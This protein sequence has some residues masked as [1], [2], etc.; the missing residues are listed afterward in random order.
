MLCFEDYAEAVGEGEKQ[1][2]VD[3]ENQWIVVVV[4]ERQSL[5]LG[6]SWPVEMGTPRKDWRR[7]ESTSQDI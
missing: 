5:V 4:R 7:K 2:I 3:R 1:W 6:D